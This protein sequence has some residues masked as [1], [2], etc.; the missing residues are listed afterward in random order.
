MG[1]TLTYRR[2]N[3]K[4]GG[5]PTPYAEIAV[6]DKNGLCAYAASAL[7]TVYDDYGGIS[8]YHLGSGIV[9]MLTD[10]KWEINTH[11]AFLDA[12]AKGLLTVVISAEGLEIEAELGEETDRP[13]YCGDE[14]CEW[15]CGVQECGYCIDVCR[16]Q[17]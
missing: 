1:L 7:T 16:C 10:L 14:R 17:Y 5:V 2:I 8:I 13:H 6:P 11:A 15:D 9:S 4:I 12:K 3:W